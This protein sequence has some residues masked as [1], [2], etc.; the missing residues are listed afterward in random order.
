MNASTLTFFACLLLASVGALA[1]ESDE[2]QAEGNTLYQVEIVLFANSR[3]DEQSEHWEAVDM[4]YP[5][6]MLLIEGA[7]PAD[8]LPATLWQLD[9][10]RAYEALVNDTASRSAAG[11]R[12]A[13]PASRFERGTSNR[14]PGS[15]D[16]D[17]A[18]REQQLAALLAP[19]KE[20]IFA[21]LG[22]GRFRLTGVANRLQRS[23]S[24]RVLYHMAWRQ[25]IAEAEDALPVLIQ[26]GARYDD[27]YELDGTIT[28]S[29]ARY[30]HIDT[31]LWF[32]T[33]S[34]IAG[35]FTSRDPALSE[36]ANVELAHD[37]PALFQYE[38]DR[39]SY[40]PER[41]FEL[42]QSRRMRS[43]HLH[44]LDHPAFGMLI[45]ITPVA[46]EEQQISAR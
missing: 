20:A 10:Q 36:E 24:Y 2:E 27:L 46:D 44:Y 29:R 6:N 21:A 38:S 13:G 43:D 14:S 30:L 31:R 28:I 3:F 18:A 35:A 39:R 1:A 40:M 15:A 42:I 33:F 5:A 37:F 4:Y 41:T 32:T 7:P 8:S 11:A 25:P 26:G 22:A 45:Q 19:G 17:P 34:R 16:D 12:D 9:D 23:P